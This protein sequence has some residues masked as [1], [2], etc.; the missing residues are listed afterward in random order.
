MC[1]TGYLYSVH[2]NCEYSQSYYQY[3]EPLHSVLGISCIITVLD[4][5]T[6]SKAIFCIRVLFLFS[7]FCLWTFQTYCQK[8]AQILFCLSWIRREFSRKLDI[9]SL[10]SLTCDCDSFN[11]KQ[12]Q[13][14]NEL[15]ITVWIHLNLSVR[16]SHD[17]AL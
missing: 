13:P 10:I 4:K 9:V 7:V 17:G 1:S 14:P 15:P 6:Q 8:G 12:V 5:V 2:S 16:E 3:H 11:L